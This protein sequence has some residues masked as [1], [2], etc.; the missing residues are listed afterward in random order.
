[1]R[2]LARL[3]AALALVWALAVLA[4]CG[5]QDEPRERSRGGTLTMA[6]ASDVDFLD[7]GRSYFALGLQV[8]LATQRPLYSYRGLD[9]TKPVS[10]LASAP[11]AVSADGLRITIPLRRGVRFSPPVNRPATSRDVAYAFE[12]F[13]SI[14]VAGPYPSY[15]SD[16]IGVPTN[17]T[18]GVRA[19]SG[20]TTPDAQT[21]V[22]R[23]RRPTSAAFIG[24]LTLP[25]SAPVPEEYAKQFDAHSP[26]TYNE[27]VV[28]TGPYMVRSDA[29]GNTVGYKAGSTIELVRNPNWRRGTDDRPARVDAIRIRTNASDSTIAARQVLAGSHRIL[30]VTPPAA[31]LKDL[32]EQRSDQ[33]VRLPPGGY[34]FVP[35]NTTIKPF[36]NLNVRKA[37]LAVFDRNAVRLA[38]GGEVTGPLATHLLPFGIPGYEQAGGAHGPGYDFL[39]ADKPNGDSAL[40]SEYMK[41]AGYPSGK[42]TG[43]ERFLAVAGNTSGEQSVAEVVQAQLAK[44]GFRLRLRIVPDDALFTSWCSVPSRK[45]V[46][47][48]SGI[49]WLKDFPDPQPMLQPVFDGRAITPISNNNYSEL[50][51]PEIN[52]AM[53]RAQLLTGQARAAAWGAIDRMIMAQ[54]PVIPL[55]WDVATLIRSKDVIGVPNA[56]FASWDLSFMALK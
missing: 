14:N 11:P 21:I 27:H 32:S 41:K 17:P 5:G 54:A 2:L 7:P 13:F 53:T 44:L 10:D 55:Q 16:L 15:F 52:A 26:S 42:Y 30:N 20:I 29:Q 31:V 47:C 51:D 34:R 39:D 37:V 38:R 8:S 43:D 19:I 4:A 35:I 9:L 40:A 45:V 48:A 28:A 50:N 56:F 1:V 22:F 33:G 24:A 36:D 6:A 18:K 23:L 3:A 25:I 12:R 46:F 49:S